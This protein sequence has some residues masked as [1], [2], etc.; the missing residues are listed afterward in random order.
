M[1]GFNKLAIAA[2]FALASNVAR[3]ADH[4]NIVFV[5]TDN[6]GYGELGVY[7]G[8]ILRGAATPRIDG[9]AAEGT[10]LLN[11]NVEPSCTPTR[12]AVMV[13]RHPIRSGTFS[14][15]IDGRPYGLVQWEVTIAELLSQQGY[16]TGH[17]GKWHLGDSEGRYPN[18]QGFD[19]WWGIPN[20]SDESL[21]AQQPDFAA[22]ATSHLEYVMEGRRGE[23]SKKIKVYN[24]EMR[25]AMDEEVTD[26]TIDF[27]KRSVKAG[28]P[29]YAY[30]PL[31]QT[32]FPT[33]PSRKWAGKTGN[34]N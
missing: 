6:F 13:G 5:M 8:G 24:D 3:G 34:G 9:L 28:K 4:P 25:R 32:H 29:F 14:V 23:P 11:F 16:A 30:V 12:S 26:R 1:N 18:D 10:R 7:G 19:E 22:N 15:P 17:F 21:W 27:M 2:L 31:T 20:S 33:E